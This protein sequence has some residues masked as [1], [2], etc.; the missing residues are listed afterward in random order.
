MNQPICEQVNGG[1]REILARPYR[2]ASAVGLGLAL[3]LLATSVLAVAA[4]SYAYGNVFAPLFAL[5]D[6]ALVVVCFRLVWRSG[7]D[8]DR[9]RIDA[10]HVRIE[11]Q[12]DAGHSAAEYPTTWVRVWR[13][14]KGAGQ[15]LYLGAYGRRTEVGSFLGAEQRDR[16]EQIIKT[17]L[18]EAR[19]PSPS[20]S[21]SDFARGQLA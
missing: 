8:C 2:S 9:I 13:E 19:S 16:L 11:R 1:V 15:A 6:I 18:S 5:V 17:R 4:F 10:S 12:R 20:H 3:G 14:P 21:I 7:E